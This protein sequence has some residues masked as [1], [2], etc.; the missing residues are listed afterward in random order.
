MV[1]LK[2][3]L[4]VLAAA[5]AVFAAD[6]GSGDTIKIENQSDLEKYSTCKTI[7]GDLKIEKQAEGELS[8]NG[9]QQIDGSFTSEGAGNVTSISAAE[10][11]SI[12]ETFHLNGLTSLSSL[13]MGSL[14]KVGSIEF[15]ALPQLQSLGFEK[16]VTD[17]GDVHIAN[18][19]LTSLDGISLKRVGQLDI[20]DNRD[21]KKVNVENLKNAT[22][23]MNFAGN[24]ES[25]KISLPNL[26]GAKNMTFRNVSDASF[27]S[28]EKLSGQ[29]G[30]WGLNFETFSA[31]NLTETGDLVFKGNEKLSNISMPNLKTINGGFQITRNDELK[32]LDF[33]KLEQVSGAIDFSGKFDKVSLG[34]LENVR[35]GFNMQS[36]GNFSC[37]EF[38]KLRS[39]KV[40]R[41]SYKCEGNK[42][43]PTSADGKSGATGTSGGKDSESSEGASV[44]NVANVPAM[45]MAA[46]FGALL[47]YAL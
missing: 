10:L 33:P 24:S 44:M 7:K 32:S 43:N 22:G 21:M 41:G 36:T 16:G 30:F 26:A 17:A 5:S 28:L 31:P 25:L 19:G 20:T 18:T 6:C 39:D 38:K 47:Q 46:V 27:P 8:L 13:K 29:L 12:K 45:G 11:S 40:I 1:V 35:G 2:Y 3:A 14:T 23:L 37:G 9:V 15:T 34:A 42:N 4:P